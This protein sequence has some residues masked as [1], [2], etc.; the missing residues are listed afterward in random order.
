MIIPTIT[1]DRI[2][3]ATTKSSLRSATSRVRSFATYQDVHGEGE[4]LERLKQERQQLRQTLQST[5]Q[6]LKEVQTRIQLRNPM[7]APSTRCKKPNQI[8]AHHQCSASA[9][10]TNYHVCLLCS[11]KLYQPPH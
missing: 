1:M 3:L 11:Y 10:S 6:A 7:L 5:Q 2:L 9:F 8:T 4:E